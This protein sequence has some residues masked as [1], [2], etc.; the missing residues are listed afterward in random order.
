M[1]F[2]LNLAVNNTINRA[3]YPMTATK[4]SAQRRLLTNISGIVDNQEKT[5]HQQAEPQAVLLA[6]NVSK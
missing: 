2:L 4:P 6:K 5:A 3:F 1:N